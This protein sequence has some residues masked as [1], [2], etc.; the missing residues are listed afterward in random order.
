MTQSERQGRVNEFEQVGYDAIHIESF[1][2]IVFSVVF[3]HFERLK[4]QKTQ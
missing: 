3:E 1:R 4:R 2:P